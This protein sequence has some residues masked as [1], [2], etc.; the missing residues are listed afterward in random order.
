M[1]YPTL[2][3]PLTYKE[4]WT[5]QKGTKHNSS[6]QRMESETGAKNFGGGGVALP[7]IKEGKQLLIGLATQF[8]ESQFYPNPIVNFKESA[9]H[10]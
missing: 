3:V 8:P 6:S 9:D 2:V 10:R 5:N 4:Q 1:L 7:E